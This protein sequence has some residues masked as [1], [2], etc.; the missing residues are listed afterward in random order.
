MVMEVVHK[1]IFTRS[2]C[3]KHIA[4]FVHLYIH[5]SDLRSAQGSRPLL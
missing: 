3:H 5:Y 1:Y 2:G 4:E